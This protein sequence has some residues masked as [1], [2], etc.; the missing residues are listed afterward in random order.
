MFCKFCGNEIADGV[1]YCPKCGA[2]AETTSA[3]TVDEVFTSE[4]TATPTVDPAVE[5]AKNSRATKSLVFGILSLVFGS[6]VGLIFAILGIKNAKAYAELNRGIIEGKAKAG[7][8]L[9]TIG[10][11]LSIISFIYNLFFSAA[12]TEIINQMMN[13]M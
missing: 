12:M 6:I 4:F 5:Q 7:K 1:K 11:P 10:I 3:P 13:Q 2:A 8:I 9:S